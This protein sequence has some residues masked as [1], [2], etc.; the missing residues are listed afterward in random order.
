MTPIRPAAADPGVDSAAP[1]ITPAPANAASPALPLVAP[2]KPVRKTLIRSLDLD[3]QIEPI[4]ETPLFA[5][6]AGF[7]EKIYVDLGDRVTGPQV[8][9]QGKV[10]REG[11]LLLVL[12]IPELDEDYRQKEASVAQAQTEITQAAAGLKVAKSAEVSARAKVD[13][14]EAPL[15]N[16]QAEYD[17]AAAESARLKKLGDRGSATREVAEE[18][19]RIFRAAD[20]ARKQTLARI[21]SARTA[22]A[23]K[24]ALIEKAE[25]DLAAAKKRLPAAEADLQRVKVLRTY[26]EIRAPYDGVITLRNVQ[27]GQLVQPAIAGDSKPLFVVVQPQM[28]RMFVDVPELDSSVISIGS[29]L[30]VRIALDASETRTATVARTAWKFDAETRTLRTELHLENAD[31]KLRPGMSA[32]VR[33]KVAERI[34]AL[35][36]P[37]SAVVGD[38]APF[39]FTIDATNQIVRTKIETGLR[40][41]DE[42]EIVSGLSGDE[43]VV[44][45]NP[46]NFREGQAVQVAE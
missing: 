16:V 40:A 39:C 5:K 17:I 9:D 2:I 32:S 28:L 3:G 41:G 31:G 30:A 26:R 18:K 4:Q 20:S 34:D 22:V 33:L 10:A 8:D 14:A 12:A 29:D 36:L 24:Q 7:V 27:A 38:S 35:T 37:Q 46:A 42:I 25:A 21:A 44:G 23:E 45:V 15:G 13:E 43:Q 6:L 19:E 1:G 11:Q